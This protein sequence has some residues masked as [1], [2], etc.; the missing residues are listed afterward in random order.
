MKSFSHDFSILFTSKEKRKILYLFIGM[1]LMGIIEVA[2]VASIGPFMA[3]VSDPDIIRENQNLTIIYT[4]F[5]YD[6]DNEFLVSLGLIVLLM[7]ITSNAFTAL[8]TW[9]ITLFVKM[10]NHYLSMKLMEKYL[11][12][13]YLYFLGKNSAELGKNILIEVGRSIEGVILPV[14]LTASKI[15]VTLCIVGF[16][17]FIDPFIALAIL[18]VLGGAYLI[19]F[20][21]VKDRLSKIGKLTKEMILSRFKI[22][23]EAMSGIKDLKLRNNEEE[24]IRRF[25]SPSE[26]LARFSS[27]SSLI[28][29]LP[30]YALEA[31]AFGGIVS[32]IIVLIISGK[33]GNEVIPIISLYALAGYRLMPALQIIYAGVT[34][35]RYNYPALR[36]LIDDLSRLKTYKDPEL[37]SNQKC[38]FSKAIELRD[39]SFSYPQSEKE[40]IDTFNLKIEKNTTIGI[41]GATGSGKTTLVD[42]ILCLLRPHKGH[43]YIDEKKIN[44]QNMISWQKN[45]GYVPQTIYL[46]D[47]TLENNIAFGIPED[48]IDISKV[49]QAAK[50]AQLDKFINGLPE[51]Y[52]TLVGE[53]GVRLSGGQRQRIGIARALYHN[54]KVLVM[55]EATSSLDRI[56]ENII[57]ETIN[58]FSHKKTIIMVAHRLATIKECDVIHIIDSG[59]V[60]DSGD[61]NSLLEKNPKFKKLAET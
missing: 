57:I 16:L 5:E 4:Y 8:I 32:I 27:Q 6:S 24:F 22:T 44:N 23:N 43:I 9:R 40:I 28:S 46:T 15:V 17:V 21:L 30:R 35:S 12:Q 20:K 3:V 25:E 41:V 56:T 37:T 36:T 54:P 1:V 13:P 49:K 42:I 58:N 34:G 48:E 7:L 59:R 19:I 52:N 60:I 33:K 14:M 38:D 18:L 26:D 51:G 45:L 55:D 50:W 2:G 61:Y 29:T 10:Q 39:I 47:D 11:Y 31:L 53:R